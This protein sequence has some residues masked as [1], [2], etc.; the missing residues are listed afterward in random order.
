[1]NSL[2]DV[3]LNDAM[4]N[5]GDMY[6]REVITILGQAV[7]EISEKS[8]ADDVQNNLIFNQKSGLKVSIL[9]LLKITANFL[10]E[11]F[12]VNCMDEREK[13]VV[14]FLKVLKSVTRFTLLP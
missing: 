10:M 9:N 3:S 4:N 12:L 1:M 11:Y 5:S 2:I 8:V 13:E 14:G 7:N 6:R